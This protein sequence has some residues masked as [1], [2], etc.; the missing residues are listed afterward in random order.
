MAGTSAFQAKTSV[1]TCDNQG[2]VQQYAA[3]AAELFGWSP[4]EVIGKMSVAMFHVPRNV[5]TLVPRLLRTAVETGKFEEEVTLVRKDASTFRA[6]LTVRPVVRDGAQV[7]FMGTTHPLGP[8]GPVPVGRLWFQALRAPFLLASLVPGLV[9]ILAAWQAGYAVELGLAGLA[10]VGLACVH[11]GTNMANDAWDFRSGNDLHVGHLNPFA[12]GG[13]VLFRGVLD[14]RTHLGVALAFLVAGSLIGLVLVSRVGLPLLWIG[15]LGVAFGYFY[16]APPLRLAYHGVGEVAVGVAFGPVTV[17]G[18]YLV[19]SGTV[20]PPAVVLSLSL[21]LLVAGILW[22]NE[23]PDIPADSAVGKRTLVVRLGVRRSTTV[24]GGIVIAA[25]AVLAI[26]VALAGLT[27]WA[28]LGLLGLP[29]AVKPILGLR[30]AGGDPHA[31]IPSNA[32]M[33]LATLVTGVL[34]LVGLGLAALVR[35]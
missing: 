2:I 17:L 10:L 31:L 27:P 12:G 6:I 26:G 9:G 16:V 13:R 24:F 20:D 8:P 33:I 35:L 28:L 32:G 34:I 30:K 29:V 14:V 15:M 22:I 1:I 5:P 7:G 19:A 21:G 23:V 4:D 11:L 18:T 3:D 25:Y